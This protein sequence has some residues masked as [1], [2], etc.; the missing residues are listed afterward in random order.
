MSTPLW[1]TRRGN[2]SRASRVQQRR[3]RARAAVVL[4]RVL[5][6]AAVAFSPAAPVVA[7]SAGRVANGLPAPFET[8]VAL[9]LMTVAVVTVVE[10]A[11]AAASRLTRQLDGRR[12]DPSPGDAESEPWLPGATRPAVLGLAVLLSGAIVLGAAATVG[13]WWWLVSAAALATG[14]LGAIHLSPA[15]VA[16]VLG[17]RPLGDPA[18]AARLSALSRA[19]GVPIAAID[20]VASGERPEPTAFVAGLGRHRRIFLSSVIVREW[21]PG[22][23]DVVVAHELG[24]H[25]RGDLWRSLLVDTAVI[26]GGLAVAAIAASAGVVSAPSAGVVALPGIA[27][28]A[29]SFWVV[30]A[31]LRHAQSRHQERQADAFALRL[32]GQV[33][34]FTSVIR[35]LGK[36][37]VA[38]EQPTPLARWMTSRHPTVSERLRAAD[39][40]RQ[41]RS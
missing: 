7:A 34:A 17:A 35:R 32:T 9:I 16:A 14:A 33:E 21:Q 24:H 8:L 15:L 29:G 37:H 10:L 18:T 40:F 39:R 26:G 31:P 41:S 38:D 28:V 30:S 4:A 6:L 20:E 27:W 19:A 36:I 25:R 3:R 13:P 1:V 23:I 5:A 11:A 2:Q 12:A 22:E